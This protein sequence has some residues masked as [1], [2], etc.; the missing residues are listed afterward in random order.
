MTKYIKTASIVAEQYDGSDKMF[1]KYNMMDWGTMNG[2]R[3]SDQVFIQTL[4]GSLHVHIGDWIATGI[5][6]EHWVIAADIF[7]RTYRELTVIPEAV[8][9]FIEKFSGGETDLDT[10][11]VATA[12]DAAINWGE[13]TDLVADWIGKNTDEFAKAYLDGYEIEAK[14]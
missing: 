13:S 10:I 5:K 3:H 8:G 11:N 1:K 6:G 7:K 2:L 12:I 9:D 14:S 4:E